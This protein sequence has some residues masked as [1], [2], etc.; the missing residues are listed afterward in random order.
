MRSISTQDKCIPFAAFLKTVPFLKNSRARLKTYRSRGNHV[1]V[2]VI[3]QISISAKQLSPNSSSP[4][5]WCLTYMLRMMIQNFFVCFTC[6]VLVFSSQQCSNKVQAKKITLEMRC[7]GSC[8]PLLKL[9]HKC[10]LKRS[11]NF[12]LRQENIIF[13]ICFLYLKNVMW[14]LKKH[15][16]RILHPQFTQYPS[17]NSMQEKFYQRWMTMSAEDR[18]YISRGGSSLV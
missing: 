5:Q 6:L 4:F 8:R 12:N 1:C 7:W 9:F 18:D 17:K 14:L 2:L 10:V 16:I 11:V 3:M 15:Q 13:L